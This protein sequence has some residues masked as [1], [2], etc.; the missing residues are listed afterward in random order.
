VRATQ[1]KEV[2]KMKTKQKKRQQ[3]FT[4]IE[5]M[6]VVAIIAVLA[7]MGVP[8]VAT[9]VHRGRV[10]ANRANERLLETALL[11]FW[12]ERDAWPGTLVA[13][14]APTWA[15]IS[16]ALQVLVT[17]GYIEAVPGIAGHQPDEWLIEW[18]GPTNRQ[19]P[20]VVIP[21]AAPGGANNP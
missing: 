8:A 6:A 4:L 12:T 3:G 14:T 11:R 1:R 17:E 13:G 7:T 19:V 10:T 9:A 16:A 21:A 18:V 5:L 20:N 2:N 15:V